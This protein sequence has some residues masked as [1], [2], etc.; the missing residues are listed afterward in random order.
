VISGLA[1]FKNKVEEEH[2]DWLSLLPS[3]AAMVVGTIVGLLHR[4]IVWENIGVW[5]CVQ[6]RI[7]SIDSVINCCKLRRVDGGRRLVVVTGITSKVTMVMM[8][9]SVSLC[10]N[11]HSLS[12]EYFCHYQGW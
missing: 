8:T 5:E 11:T 4:G 2:R 3:K 12:T 9:L 6:V 10:R 7:K 1:V